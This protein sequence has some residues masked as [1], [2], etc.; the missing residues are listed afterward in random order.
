MASLYITEFQASGN[1]ESGAQLQVG[2]Q[3]AGWFDGDMLDNPAP[4][5]T[6]AHHHRPSGVFLFGQMGR[7]DPRY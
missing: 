7:R 2:M 4:V 1:A 6:I 5:A 3:P